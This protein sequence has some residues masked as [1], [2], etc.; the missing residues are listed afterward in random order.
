MSSD[1][2]EMFGLVVTVQLCDRPTE[3]PFFGQS[4]T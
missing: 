1:L 3:S 4:E 2:V